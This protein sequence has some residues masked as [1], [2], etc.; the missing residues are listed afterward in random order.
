MFNVYSDETY[1]KFIHPGDRTVR[2]LFGYAAAATLIQAME[3]ADSSA[4]P[5]IGPFVYGTDGK[6]AKNL[7]VFN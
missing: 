2:P 1:T 5:S 6:G 4:T 7:I 3:S